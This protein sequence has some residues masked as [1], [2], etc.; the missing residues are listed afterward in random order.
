[1]TP[2]DQ[3]YADR[4]YRSGSAL[5]GGVLLLVLAGW[6]GIDAV[7]DGT[8]RTP[9]V[10]LA[11]LLCVVPLVVAFTL[12]PAVFA[13]DDRMRVRN[14]FRLITL[15]WGA[16]DG[17]RGSYTNEVHT[18]DGGKYQLWSIPVSLRERKKA[19]RRRARAESHARGGVAPD[20][21]GSAAHKGYLADADARAQ[22]DR[23]VSELREI[24][25]RNAARPEAQGTPSVRWAYEIIAPA[26]VGAVALVVL[27]ATG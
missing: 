25:E 6:L 14:P 10:A 4:A 5:A 26:A 21:A 24:A 9:W 8:G 2:P 18:S 11:A 1:M 3:R 7:V 20:R 23:A 17:I 12:R 16:V 19:A 15:P 27:W 22:G 13:N